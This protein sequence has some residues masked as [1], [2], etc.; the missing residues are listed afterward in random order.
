M[1]LGGRTNRKLTYKITMMLVSS[2]FILKPFYFWKSGLP[3]ISDFI[4]LLSILTYL[5]GSKS[6]IKIYEDS[7]RF[8]IFNCLFAYYV[9]LINTIWSLI[10]N[11]ELSFLKTSL[12]YVYNVIICIFFCNIIK[13]YSTDLYSKVYVS[14]LIS[15]VLQAILLII[16][17][18]FSGSRMTLFFNN[19]N[20]LGYY[21]LLSLAILLFL[22]QKLIIKAK[23]FI[24]GVLSSAILCLSS[25]SKAAIVSYVGIILYFLCRKKSNKNLYRKVFIF[26]SIFIILF[27]IV[28]QYNEKIFK[29]N[30]LLV[31]VQQRLLDIGKDPDDNLA[32]RGYD[33]LL[34]HKQY[35]LFGAGEG[36]YSRF[37]SVIEIHSTFG[38]IL[39]SYGFI[40]FGLFLLILFNALKQNGWTDFYLIFFI[41]LYGLTHNGVRNTQLW[42]LIAMIGTKCDYNKVT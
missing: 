19:P 10:L 20:Q 13:I 41:M 37:Q 18:G 8:I 31:S 9:F 12:F 23:W 6:R 38:N 39:M 22:S 25:L 42:I 17:G 24:V 36:A 7:R 4:L 30:V 3:Q 34:T 28:Y 27:V 21:S 33:R 26:L 5:I 2:Y 11:G 15:V 35:L 16:S 14:V 1:E 32:G 29:S 40:G